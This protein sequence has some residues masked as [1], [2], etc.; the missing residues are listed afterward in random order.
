MSWTETFSSK[1]IGAD[2]AAALVADGKLVRLQ[3]GP[4]PVTLLNALARRA[5]AAARIASKI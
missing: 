2:A 5:M 1:L 4:V 3:M